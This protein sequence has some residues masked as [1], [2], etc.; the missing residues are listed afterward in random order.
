MRGYIY[1]VTDV[2]KCPGKQIKYTLKKLSYTT[3]SNVVHYVVNNNNDD[4]TNLNKLEAS[5]PIVRYYKEVYGFIQ[6]K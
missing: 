2:A 6:K 3:N 4:S 5:D 1:Q